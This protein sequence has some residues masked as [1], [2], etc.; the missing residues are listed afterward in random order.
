MVIFELERT[1]RPAAT[2]EHRFIKRRTHCDVLPR[3]R[4]K[5]GHG[6][7]FLPGRF[8]GLPLRFR[9]LDLLLLSLLLLGHYCGVGL[10]H[11]THVFG[12]ITPAHD[13]DQAENNGND[14][15]FSVLHGGLYSWD[16][17]G[18]WRRRRGGGTG[19]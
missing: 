10:L 5:G 11:P 3:R 12:Q 17:G 4:R 16:N 7:G 18:V 13:D 6:Q 8:L 9:L 19:S 2:V 15:I 14:Q 1:Q